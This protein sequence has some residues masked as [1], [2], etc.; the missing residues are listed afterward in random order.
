L[1]ELK[2]FAENRI[3]EN[4]KKFYP[5]EE[6]LNPNM[7]F[8][9]NRVLNFLDTNK[10]FLKKEG[11]FKIN[12]ADED[13]MVRKFYN[14]L[15][16]SDFFKIYMESRHNNL[17]DDKKL[18]IKIVDR[19]MA[20]DELLQSYYQEKSVYY[21]DGYDLVTILLIKFTETVSNK[22]TENSL[23]PTLIKTE[24]DAENSD[25]EF[26]RKLYRKVI[27]NNDKYDAMIQP[28]TKNWEY[29]R[30]PMLDLILIKMALTEFEYMDEVPVK[31]SLNEYIELAKHFSVAKSKTFVNGVLDKL[32]D[33]LKSEGRINK[34]G[35]GMID[36]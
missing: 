17:D 4:K 22:S 6:E 25:L 10:D 1:H 21:V 29:D 26:V 11:L 8:V 3:E 20:G 9:N 34:L 35:R 16:A 19:L 33:E 28:R 2:R 24:N 36:K 5:T 30:I 32:I 27:L 23:L 13:E 14:K 12:W 15:F 31:V 18:I 7:K